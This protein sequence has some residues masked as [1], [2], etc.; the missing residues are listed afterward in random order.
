MRCRLFAVIV[1]LTYCAHAFGDDTE[2]RIAK[3][4]THSGGRVLR[5]GGDP[6]KAIIGLEIKGSEAAGQVLPE[7]AALKRLRQI[8]LVEAGK[9]DR[10]RAKQLGNRA[11]IIWSL[12]LVC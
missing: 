4:I 3:A 9:I 5:D 7:L 11:S 8:T 10:E 1:L 6:A 12:G 2:E